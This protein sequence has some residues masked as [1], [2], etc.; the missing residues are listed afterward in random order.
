MKKLVLFSLLT[1]FCFSA[2]VASAA[3]VLLIEVLQLSQGAIGGKKKNGIHIYFADG[4]T[5]RVDLPDAAEYGGIVSQNMI[6]VVQQLNRFYNLGYKLQD[7]FENIFLANGVADRL[8]T[9]IL[10]KE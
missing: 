9:Y 7:S 3:E 6:I 2:H 10:V 1:V 5:E 8:T 4:T